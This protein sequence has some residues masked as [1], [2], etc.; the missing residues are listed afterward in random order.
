MGGTCIPEVCGTWWGVNLY[1]IALDLATGIEPEIPQNP[2][3]QPCAAHLLWS[4]QNGIFRGTGE[5]DQ[6]LQWDLDITEGEKIYKFI[7][8]NLRIGDVI[9][10]ANTVEEAEDIV[11]SAASNF[12]RDLNVER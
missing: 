10:T 9:V 11:S 2:M 5:L 8:G 3:G 12:R 4:D 1:G 7:S 6:H